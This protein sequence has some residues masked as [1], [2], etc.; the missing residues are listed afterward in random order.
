M[1]EGWPA[2]RNISLSSVSS[3]KSMRWAVTAW[4]QAAQLVV[5][6]CEKLYCVSLVLHILLLL[7]FPLFSY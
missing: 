4:G 1:N 5:G 7:L 3:A 2:G 6:W